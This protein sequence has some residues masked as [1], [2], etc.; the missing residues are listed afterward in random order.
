MGISKKEL[1]NIKQVARDY[2]AT[3][4]FT[5]WDCYD[6][7]VHTWARNIRCVFL[8]LAFGIDNKD[9]TFF[10][11]YHGK[12]HEMARPTVNGYPCFDKVHCW[13]KEK[14]DKLREILQ[15]MISEDEK[16]LESFFC[17]FFYI[18]SWKFPYSFTTLF[19]FIFDN[20]N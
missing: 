14:E 20:F 17:S 8:P 3:K 5:S 11:M 9:Y 2:R 12:G 19:Y 18:G 16:V 10:Y 13:N 1:E 7:D 4:I 6:H 15:A